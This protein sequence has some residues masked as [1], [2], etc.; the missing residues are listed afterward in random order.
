[1][2]KEVRIRLSSNESC[3]TFQLKNRRILRVYASQ[4]SLWNSRCGFFWSS[5]LVSADH[6]GVWLRY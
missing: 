5:W 3:V 1:M 2:E 4:F 6:E